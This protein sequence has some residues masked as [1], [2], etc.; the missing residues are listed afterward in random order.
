MSWRRHIESAT[1]S[2]RPLFLVSVLTIAAFEG[3]WSLLRFKVPVVIW[4]AFILSNF[5]GAVR[6]ALS[7]LFPLPLRI[8]VQVLAFAVGF[9]LNRALGYIAARSL[10]SQF[11]HH[12]GMRPS[13]LTHG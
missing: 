5:L 9:G 10:W 2:A 3:V 12:H 13:C 1:S 6:L 7:L 11:R 8:G 4:L